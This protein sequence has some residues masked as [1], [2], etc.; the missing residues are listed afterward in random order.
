MERKNNI[1]SNCP[2]PKKDSATNISNNSF[3]SDRQTYINFL[4]NKIDT[5]QKNDL[6]ITDTSN[7]DVKTS[8]IEGTGSGIKFDMKNSDE[9]KIR[10]TECEDKINFITE[11][12]TEHFNKLELDMQKSN[13]EVKKEVK[14]IKAGK[15]IKQD[16][17]DSISID[18]S[19]LYKYVDTRFE[20]F[21]NNINLKFK[22][23]LG[24]DLKYKNN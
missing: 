4:E 23:V 16:K 21:T 22:T 10:L 15:Q 8:F 3:V 7:I 1:K 2:Q 20:E 11:Y 18:N 6:N 14:S 12:F 24:K 19:V 17:H 5:M 9:F 13:I